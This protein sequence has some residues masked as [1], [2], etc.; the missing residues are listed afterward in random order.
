VTKLIELDAVTRT[1]TTPFGVVTAVDRV[2]LGFD[3]AEVLCI[4]GESGCGKTT[5]GRLLAGLIRPTSGSLLF[6]GADVW[7]K[8]GD[9]LRRFR[10]A[11]QLVHQDPYASLNPTRTVEIGRAHV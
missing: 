7:R 5:T 2:S 3:A 1:F 11:V 10:K 8:K 9:D 6:E 4:V